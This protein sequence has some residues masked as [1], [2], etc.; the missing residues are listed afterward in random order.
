[1]KKVNEKHLTIKFIVI[2][3]HFIIITILFVNFYKLYKETNSIKSWE[4]VDSTSDYTY[5][6]ISKMSEAFATYQDKNITMHFCIEEEQTGRWHVYIIGINKDDY[7]K[8]KKIIDYSYEK[9]SEKPKPIKV[10]GYPEITDDNLK[11]VAI[12][13]ISKFLPKENEITITEENYETFL[14]NSYLDTTQSK[15]QS[16]SI[17]LAIYSFLLFFFLISLFLTL[18]N[19]DI[20]VERIYSH[21]KRTIVK[22]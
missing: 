11:K 14:T 17:D 8:Y 10:Y 5:I 19:K 3:I 7:S 13:N 1:M 9:I 18:I 20:F 4:E 12:K 15:K 21:K 16:F 22:K 2:L 6:T